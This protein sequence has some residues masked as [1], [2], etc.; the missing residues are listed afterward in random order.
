MSKPPLN[1]GKLEFDTETRIMEVPED[2]KSILKEFPT[3][4]AFFENLSF[5]HQK[6]YVNWIN[7]AKKQET[8][9]RRIVK[10]IEMLREGKGG[11]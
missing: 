10:T 7:D 8:R 3:Q 9:E 4:E 2:F 6:E 11:K 5:T 1:P